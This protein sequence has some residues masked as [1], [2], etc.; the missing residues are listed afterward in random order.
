MLGASL[1]A[2][3]YRGS[4]SDSVSKTPL[5][6]A[7]QS[8]LLPATEPPLITKELLAKD[9]KVSCRTVELW[10]SQRRIPFIKLGHRTLRFS[11]DDVRRALR[12]H[13]TVKEVQ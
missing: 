7:A 6:S 10:V 5:L 1:T 12:Q 11:L 13:W 8:A 2:R 4:K 3:R 9:L